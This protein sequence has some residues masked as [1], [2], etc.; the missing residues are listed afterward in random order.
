MPTVS[1][2]AVVGSCDGEMVAR[3]PFYNGSVKGFVPGILARVS[4][5]WLRFGSIQ[6]AAER[7]G[8]QQVVRLA[9]EAVRV[10]SGM[11]IDDGFKSSGMV[12]EYCENGGARTVLA[13][14][15]E[16][17]VVRL[18]ALVAAW[19][20][21]G[22]THGVMN[23]D[24]MS[25]VGLTMDL[26]VF[27]WVNRWRPGFT[28]NFI[29]DAKRYNFVNQRKIARWNLHRLAEALT[30]NR[31]LT[32]GN[33]RD[34]SRRKSTGPREDDA[35]VWLDPAVA[36][37]I[38]SR[39]DT[40]YDACYTRRMSQRLGLSLSLDVYH[41][42][43]RKFVIK[44]FITTA[45]QVDYFLLSRSVA[46]LGKHTNDTLYDWADQLIGVHCKG[47]GLYAF[48][49]NADFAIKQR[50]HY[51]ASLL[52]NTPGF[53]AWQS[54]R[55]VPKVYFRSRVVESVINKI[56]DPKSRYWR[57]CNF[58]SPE[59]DRLIKALS[60]PFA[61]YSSKVLELI[62][63]DGEDTDFQATCGAQ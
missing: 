56:T 19:M 53:D 63:P 54:E 35:A 15:L 60:R 33:D 44:E 61:A 9:R 14:A 37:N 7:M 1:A 43:H 22:F 62:V 42:Q 18:A 24:N 26:N 31:L 4:P 38:L 50:L 57:E 34:T 10:M 39:F 40:I 2:L 47:A 25:L 21:V 23:T 29:D 59:L 30:G 52:Q 45:K 32:A 36:R 13:C 27:G 12:L 16:Q 11:E 49:T 48:C 6:L 58:T 3:D 8:V 55:F 46:L 5:S 51:V 20:S 28:P 17:N 41:V